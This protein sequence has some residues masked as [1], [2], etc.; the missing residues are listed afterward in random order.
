[1]PHVKRWTYNGEVWPSAST[2]T[3]LL[4]SDALDNWLRIA[5]NRKQGKLA[6]KKGSALASYMEY[7][8]KGIPSPGDIFS[9]IC[10]EDI[11]SG[12]CFRQWEKWFDAQDLVILETEPHLVNTLDK[13]HGS[14]DLIASD[15]YGEAVLG[16][17]KLKKRFADYKLL[18]NEHAYAMCDSIDM[19]NGNIIPVPWEFPIE[20]IVFW[21]YD[22]DTGEMFV[23][24][25]EFIP[26][27]Y[28]DFLTLRKT[29]DIKNRAEEYF[30][31]HAT[32]L[33]SQERK[34]ATIAPQSTSPHPRGIVRD[35]AETEGKNSGN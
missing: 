27:V 26:E 28:K 22:P 8:R 1:M 24:E 14:P 17:D 9:G 7:K 19:G 13:Y 21:S 31:E 20:R 4:H 25:H 10:L 15:I 33:P 32:L 3:G 5:K 34:N 18:M 11:F 12:I 35:S 6:Q 2:V 30:T 29:Y 16:D 23:N